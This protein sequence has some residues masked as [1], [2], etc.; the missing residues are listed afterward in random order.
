MNGVQTIGYELIEQAAQMGRPIDHVF[1]CAGGG[2][3]TLAVTRGLARAV[4]QAGSGR[5]P[6]VHCVQPEGNNTMAGPLRDGL[7][8]AQACACT[9]RIGGLQ[10]P[11]VLDGDA[12]I[13]AC[14]AGGG[15][16]YLVQDEEVWNVQARLAREEGIFCEPAA[17]VPLAGALQAAQNGD[18][19]PDATVVCLVTGIGFKD[20]VSVDAMVADADCPTIS[21]QELRGRISD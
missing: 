3:L 7:D 12:V 16:G 9:P 11:S 14:R 6:A 5:S 13:A 20:E 4:E 2:G 19:D 21:I 18:I 8:R 1:S 10:V 17:A 15:T